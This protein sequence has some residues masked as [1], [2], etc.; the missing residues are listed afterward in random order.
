MQADIV[1]DLL[2]RV[3][4]LSSGLFDGLVPLLFVT[5]DFVYKRRLHGWPVHDPPALG[6]LADIY[7]AFPR[8][9]M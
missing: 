4:V 8:G 9:V 1:S 2:L 5:D 3:S 7:F 6:N